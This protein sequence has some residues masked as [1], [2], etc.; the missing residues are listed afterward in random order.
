MLKWKNKFFY[1]FLLIVGFGFN[2]NPTT[3]AQALSKN[4]KIGILTCSPG[5]GIFNAFGHSA[6]RIQDATLGIDRIYNYGVMNSKMSNFYLKFFRGDLVFHLSISKSKQFINR[7]QRQGREII[8]QELALNQSQKQQLINYLNKNYKKE[9]RFY[10]YGFYYDNCSTKIKD[11][12][13]SI[14]GNDL[15]YEKTEQVASLT[16]RQIWGAYL[17]N[18]PWACFGADFLLGK[19][20]DRLISNDEHFFLPYDLMQFLKKGR[21]NQSIVLVK[22][23]NTLIPLNQTAPVSSFQISP[24]YLFWGLF[25]IIIIIKIGFPKSNILDYLDLL[26]YVSLG[27][28][29]LV[30]L[31]FYFY[32]SLEVTKYNWNIL[33]ANPLYLGMFWPTIRQVCWNQF[34]IT[35]I[36]WIIFNL[37]IL[38]CWKM[39][40]QTFHPAV[41]PLILIIITLNMIKLSK[42]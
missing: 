33:W 21:I 27:L 25:L 7:Y 32:S 31:L 5:E 19:K 26:G 40:P 18:H 28:G 42:K 22:K 30:L 34:P 3:H 36:F 16:Y 29:G 9:N 14:L 1:S 12:L 4:A 8:Q 6:I 23:E 13:G 17:Y 10:P 38:I 41:F 20:A 35:S 2:W 24:T 39:I 37:I 11:A 15:T